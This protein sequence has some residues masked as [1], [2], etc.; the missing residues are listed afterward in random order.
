MRRLAALVVASALSACGAPHVCNPGEITNCGGCG[1]NAFGTAICRGDGTGYGSCGCTCNTGFHPGSGADCLPGFCAAGAKYNGSGCVPAAAGDI[2]FLWSFGGLT[3]AQSGVAN[4]QVAL[5]GPNGPEPLQNNGFYPCTFGGADG[6][7]L[8]AFDGGDY[9]F[10]L[11]GLA[12]GGAPLYG[13]SGTF[14]VDGSV[15]V[16]VNLPRL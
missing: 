4:V 12:L 5:T 13:A 3:C 10:S 7:T 14:A 6:V 16:R 9:T 2:T 8:T 15:Q 1:A 11:D